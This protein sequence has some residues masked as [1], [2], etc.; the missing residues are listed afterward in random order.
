L[1]DP[2]I[3]T[4]VRRYLAAVRRAGISVQRAILFGSCA[5]GEDRADSDVDILVIAPEFDELAGR[6][7]ADVLWALR[8]TTDSR[9]EP[10]AVGERQWREDAVSVI[11]EV[12]RREGLEISA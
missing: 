11:I 4:T 2:A 12:A 5:R 3:V 1:V 8:A 6:A 9:I 10:F 7:R